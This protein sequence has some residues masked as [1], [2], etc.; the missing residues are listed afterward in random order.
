MAHLC[1]QPGDAMPGNRI[2]VIGQDVVTV[3]RVSR[4]CL[5]QGAEVFPYYGSPTLEE[6]T[7]FDPEVSILCLPL[8]QSFLCNLNQQYIV[9]SEQP[10][11]LNLPSV[12]TKRE[13]ENSLQLAL[14]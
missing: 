13:L 12:S 6:V 8:P 3:Q 7:L 1:H 10:L 2:M 5:E 4:Y 11:K 9:W 14:H